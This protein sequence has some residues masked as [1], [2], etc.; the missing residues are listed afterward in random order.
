[1]RADVGE[2]GGGG[3]GADLAGVAAAAEVAVLPIPRHRAVRMTCSNETREIDAVRRQADADLDVLTLTGQVSVRR[4][5][6]T[7]EREIDFTVRLVLPTCELHSRG[8]AADLRISRQPVSRIGLKVRARRQRDRYS[9][10]DGNDPTDRCTKHGLNDTSHHHT[11]IPPLGAGCFQ[12]ELA[13]SSCPAWVVNTRA[14][15]KRMTPNAVK[16]DMPGV[17]HID[18][19]G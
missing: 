13:T 7:R 10:G 5:R 17:I 11:G 12:A 15:F 14:P 19:R 18:G 16:I 4:A 3:D 1:R 2:I 9:G 8:E 6:F